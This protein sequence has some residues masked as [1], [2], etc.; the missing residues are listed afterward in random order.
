MYVDI[1]LYLPG[2]NADMLLRSV[3]NSQLDK[4]TNR[5]FQNTTKIERYRTL[6]I[7]TENRTYMNNKVRIFVG[8]C[9]LVAAYLKHSMCH[10]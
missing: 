2:H 5:L 10:S 7:Y 8:N 6:N 3:P 4:T 9:N 1:V